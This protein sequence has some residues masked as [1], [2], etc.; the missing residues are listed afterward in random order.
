MVS[1]G[2]ETSSASLIVKEEQAVSIPQGLQ[3]KVVAVSKRNMRL[4][5][6]LLVNDP[7]GLPLGLHVLHGDGAKTVAQYE[8]P[9]RLP[10]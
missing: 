3:L 9:M 5:V 6:V 10:Y 7:A 1:F 2:D 8:E 4:D